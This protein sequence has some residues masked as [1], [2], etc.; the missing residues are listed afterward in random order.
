[1][2]RMVCVLGL[3]LADAATGRIVAS[4]RIVLTASAQSGAWSVGATD[5]NMLNYLAD[6]SREYLKRN[7]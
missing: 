6:I 3:I 1:M 7:Y 2:L 4:P 5:K